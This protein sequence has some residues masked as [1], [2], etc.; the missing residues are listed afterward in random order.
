[1]L[2]IGGSL[3][4]AAKGP[5]GIKIDPAKVES[6]VQWY[7]EESGRVKKTVSEWSRPR[8]T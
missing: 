4:V 8:R 2:S 3:A 5:P 6:P 7:F 1:M